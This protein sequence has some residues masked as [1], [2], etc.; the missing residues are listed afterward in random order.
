MERNV[1]EGG[2]LEEFIHGMV[3]VRV[4]CTLVHFR[5]MVFQLKHSTVVTGGS[6][7]TVR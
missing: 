4:C 2:T 5:T 7:G 6:Y 3:A 1:C